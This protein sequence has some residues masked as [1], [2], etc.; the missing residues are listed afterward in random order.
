MVKN[1]K[2]IILSQQTFELQ[3]VTE[4]Q[5]ILI[6]IQA[7]LKQSSN[8]IYLDLERFV[9]VQANIIKIQ[10]EKIEQLERRVSLLE[11]SNFS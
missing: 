3:F 8:R 5:P 4:N 6:E 2:K 1:M 11:Q 7:H 9:I 10:Q